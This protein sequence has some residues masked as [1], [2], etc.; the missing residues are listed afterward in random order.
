MSVFTV[1]SCG[2][3]CVEIMS[4]EKRKCWQYNCGHC[5]KIHWSRSLARSQYQIQLNCS[6]STRK[7][8]K[9]D[10]KWIQCSSCKYEKCD[11]HC[12]KNI[13]L[14]LLTE[15]EWKKLIKLPTETGL[16]TLRDWTEDDFIKQLN[17]IE[18]KKKS[19]KLNKSVKAEPSLQL[20][21]S[22]TPEASSLNA[23]VKIE[24]GCDDDDDD[25]DE[26]T[27]NDTASIDD[28]RI[29]TNFTANSFVSQLNLNYDE[30]VIN[31]NSNN[32]INNI[33]I[34][35]DNDK[36]ENNINHINNNNNCMVMIS[37]NNNDDN[38]GSEV[39]IQN[40]TNNNSNNI[41]IDN[42]Y[43]WDNDNNKNMI[44]DAGNYAFIPHN[45][46]MCMVKSP[47]EYDVLK[48]QQ[49]ID[50]YD[51]VE[52]QS[53]LSACVLKLIRLMKSYFGQL[54]QFDKC[55]QF[56]EN[57]IVQL[58]DAFVDGTFKQEHSGLV[59]QYYRLFVREA[60]AA[61]GDN[62]GDINSKG[63]KKKF[64]NQ[65]RLGLIDNLTFVNPQKSIDKE[66]KIDYPYN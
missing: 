57:K 30:D 1:L 34:I 35:N 44:N 26:K 59:Y 37:T 54:M 50:E 12:C 51:G 64:E 39:E 7:M 29:N 58:Y 8:T 31:N 47:T 60:F 49:V 3:L 17:S 5:G 16:Y 11:G 53:A 55:D 62:Y 4:E 2:S 15:D 65:V 21:E 46:F 66:K 18:G 61:I 40:Q 22:V 28:G 43:D 56:V 48:L 32:N 14:I 10:D 63:N 41:S 6:K 19:S 9:D 52:K 27:I 24:S 45:Q 33:N 20:G 13:S 42:N 23:T 25:D 36:K 38:A